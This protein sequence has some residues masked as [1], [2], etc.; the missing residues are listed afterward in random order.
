MDCTCNDWLL[1]L[2]SSRDLYYILYTVS[3]W[4]WFRSRKIWDKV[5]GRNYRDL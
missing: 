5:A 3:I 1:T 2:N 4:S